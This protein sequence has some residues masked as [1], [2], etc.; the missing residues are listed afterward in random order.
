VVHREVYTEG[1]GTA[2]PGTDVQ[3]LHM[4]LWSRGDPVGWV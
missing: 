4:R 3:E 2:K 1:S